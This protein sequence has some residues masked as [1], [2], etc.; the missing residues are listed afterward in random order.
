MACLKIALIAYPAFWP[1]WRK[2]GV[3]FVVVLASSAIFFK[4]LSMEAA[5]WSLVDFTLTSLLPMLDSRLFV[6]SPFP[7]KHWTARIHRTFFLRTRIAS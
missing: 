3:T 2:E 7:S 5:V 1:R 4:D 6:P